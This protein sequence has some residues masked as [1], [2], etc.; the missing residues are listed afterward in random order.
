MKLLKERSKSLLLILWLAITI[1][2]P[3]GCQESK[4]DKG[5]KTEWTNCDELIQYISYSNYQGIS[6][7]FGEGIL[8]KPWN[9]SAL[10]NDPLMLIKVQ[11][12]KIRLNGKPLV[13][14]FENNFSEY[15]DPTGPNPG[16]FYAVICDGDWSDEISSSNSTNTN[17]NSGI[18]TK[19]EAFEMP[20]DDDSNSIGKEDWK[21]YL[22]SFIDAINE[23]ELSAVYVTT[24]HDT[25]FY[26]RS[27]VT[28]RD[29]FNRNNAWDDMAKSLNSGFKIYDKHEG[30]EA[31]RITK[32]N[33]LIFVYKD[34]D[35]RWYGVI[36]D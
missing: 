3:T 25:I 22:S 29:F 16:K 30:Y 6:S 13:V 31:A 5:P 11:F 26:D 36:G 12:P 32:D 19:I 10:A 4:K 2:L 21:Y 20:T 23:K 33:R 15:G 24:V 27:G 7:E 35:W 14:E 34:E 8:G 18:K 17:E 9:A 28:I 1:S